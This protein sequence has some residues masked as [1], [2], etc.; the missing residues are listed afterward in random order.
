MRFYVHWYVHLRL[1]TTRRK[2]KREIAVVDYLFAPDYA[3]RFTSCVT[4]FP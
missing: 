2:E 1:Y 4:E 3:H